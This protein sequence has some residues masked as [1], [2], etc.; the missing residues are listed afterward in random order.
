[1]RN[2]LE[3]ARDLLRK[4]GS[5]FVT[6]NDTDPDNGDTISHD[7]GL[8]SINKVTTSDD[9]G[10]LSDDKYTLSGTKGWLSDNSG[11]GSF[12]KYF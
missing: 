5:I 6:L 9:E 2:R 1:M 11:I 3:V 8:K 12:D 10:Y 7:K 4:E